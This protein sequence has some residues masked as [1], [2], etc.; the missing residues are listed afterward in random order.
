MPRGDFR[1]PYSR[2]Q[3]R[4]QADDDLW[5]HDKAPP[6]ET[7]SSA[8]AQTKLR[9]ENLHYSVTEKDLA[10]IFGVIGTLSREPMIRYDRSGR[11]TGVAT[12]FFNTP[13]EATRA[14]LQLN[15]VMAKGEQMKI[16]IETPPT[17]P[18][19]LNGGSR[20]I[21]RIAKPPLADRIRADQAPSGPGPVRHRTP[22]GPAR[23]RGARP[24]RP[25]RPANKTAEELDKELDNFMVTPETK[26]DDVDMA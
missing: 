24:A 16:S 10:T 25:A 26:S 20:L 6:P 3:P 12:V 1:K 14:K 17:G 5:V 23:G 11:S 8:L 2:P 19:N 22:R 9:V 18:R 4:P 13:A 7:A 15:G 21:D